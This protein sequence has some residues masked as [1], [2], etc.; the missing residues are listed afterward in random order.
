MFRYGP[1]RP[2]QGQGP[3]I[4]IHLAPSSRIA[5]GTD[6][7]CTVASILPT[8]SM[9]VPPKPPAH[10][11]EGTQD[12]SE[13]DTHS[14]QKA[15]PIKVGQ[16]WRSS[17][18]ISAKA[19]ETRVTNYVIGT[20]GTCPVGAPPLAGD[21]RRTRTCNQGIKSP[22]LCQIE[23]AGHKRH[24][25]AKGLFVK[26]RGGLEVGSWKLEVGLRFADLLIC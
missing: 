1:L 11:R 18:A 5:S 2:P 26:A 23:L 20:P 7:S 14:K 8:L 13:A 24:Y 22:L 17:G 6:V 10:R 9:L 3:A 19:Q 21:P 15:P 4:V 25:S 16:P 12:G